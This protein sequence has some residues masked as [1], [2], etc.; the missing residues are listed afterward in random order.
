M[1]TNDPPVDTN[2][3]PSDPGG[4]SGEVDHAGEDGGGSDTVRHVP[5]TETVSNHEETKVIYHIDD[6]ETPYKVTVSA[7]NFNSINTKM[8]FIT[9]DKL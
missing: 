4:M 9:I 2:R 8:T 3:C 7:S 1:E 6:E 5:N